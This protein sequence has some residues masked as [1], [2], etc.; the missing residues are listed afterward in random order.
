MSTDTPTIGQARPLPY[1]KSVGA[2]VRVVAVIA[3]LVTIYYI[4]PLDRATAGVA[5]AALAGGLAGLAVLV[6]IQI[7]AVLASPFPVLR[8]VEALTTSAVLFLLLY[9]AAYV[10][11]SGASTDNFGQALTHTDALYFTVTTFSTVGFG[12]VTPKTQIARLVVTG[13][14]IADLAFLGIVIKALSAAARRTSL[15]KKQDS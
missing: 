2:V 6:V 9:A 13:Q 4:L 11:L 12:D 7:R 1:S 8:A 15:R 14:M 10:A 5:I 3:L